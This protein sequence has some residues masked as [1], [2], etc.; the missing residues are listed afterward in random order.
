MS[1]R[2]F[3]GVYATDSTVLYPP[4]TKSCMS[5]FVRPAMPYRISSVEYTRNYNGISHTSSA[6][7]GVGAPGPPARPSSYCD[8]SAS[9]LILAVAIRTEVWWVGSGGDVAGGEVASR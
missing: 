5:R 7:S 2:V 9:A 3:F 4:S 1:M 6:P 8:C